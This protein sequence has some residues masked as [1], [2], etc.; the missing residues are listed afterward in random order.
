HGRS[1]HDSLATPY[2][3]GDGRADGRRDSGDSHASAVSPQ[4]SA[5]DAAGQATRLSPPK[6]P[7][8]TPRNRIADYENALS[9]LPRKTAE[10]PVFEVVKRSRKPGD[11]SSPIGELPNGT[12]TCALVMDLKKARGHNERLTMQQRS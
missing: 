11:K 2:E 12:V 8:P 1:G 3:L 6:T 9:V 10:G 5:V 7:S 4:S